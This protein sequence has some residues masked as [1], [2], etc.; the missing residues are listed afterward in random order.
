MSTLSYSSYYY[1]YQSYSSALTV[2]WLIALAVSVITIIGMWKIFVKAGKPGWAAIVPFYNMYILFEITWGEGIKFL[3][4]LIPIANI[5]FIIVTYIKLAKAFGKTGGFAAG[6]VLLAPVFVNILGFGPDRYLGIPDGFGGFKQPGAQGYTQ[7]P[8][9][10][11]AQPG[12]YAQQPQ[13]PQQGY[14]QQQQPQQ[15]PPQ[16]QGYPYPQQPQQRPP[17]QQGY[18]IRSSHKQRP[19]NSKV[20]PMRSNRNSV[21]RNSRVTL[22]AAAATASAATTG[23]LPIRSSRSNVRRN[24]RATLSA[25]A[26]Q[27]PPQQPQQ[28]QGPNTNPPAGR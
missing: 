26:Q 24:N 2:A 25:A 27:R 6:L 22:S 9:Q 12:S 11:Y 3:F 8:Q 16:Q 28:G 10:G 4:L 23:L 7:Q 20:T 15:R 19:R 21:R 13:Q 17:Q 5:Y 18:P 1:D 14:P